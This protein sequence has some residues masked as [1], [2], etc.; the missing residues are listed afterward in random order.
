MALSSRSR[1]KSRRHRRLAGHRGVDRARARCGRRARRRCRAQRR[2]GCRRRSGDHVVRR[3]GRGHA[4]RRHGSRFRLGRLQGN[5]RK[6]R[7]ARHPREQRRH[8]RRRAHPRGI[9]EGVVG[10]RSS[11]PI[12]PGS[13]SAPRRLPGHAEKTRPRAHREH[14]VRRGAHGEP[15]PDELRR[16]EG[17]RHRVHES[18]RAGDRLAGNHRECRRTRLHRDLHDGRAERGPEEGAHRPDRPRAA[19]NARRR[20]GRRRLPRVRTRP[21]TSPGPVST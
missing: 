20:G 5:R 4:P 18:P 9:F 15:G 13:F 3:L 11:R 14:R 2:Q 16:G 21:P 8:H 10:T 6:A 17:R 7:Q 19:R 1:E 12:S